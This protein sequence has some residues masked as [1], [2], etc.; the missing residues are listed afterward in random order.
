[1]KTGTWLVVANSSLARIFKLEKKAALVE[2]AQFE[3]PESRLH[4]RDLVSDKA[5]RTNESIGFTRHQYEPRHSPKQIEFDFFA[6]SLAQYLEESRN[7][8]EFGR[9]YIAASPTLLGLLRQALHP[10]TLK[11]LAGEVDKDMTHM[12]PDEILTHLPFLLTTF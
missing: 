3:H 12:R 7:K 11:L 8:G 4:I 5:G 10:S 2:V 9:L 6:K 1:M